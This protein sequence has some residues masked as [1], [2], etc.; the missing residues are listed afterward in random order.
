MILKID[1]PKIRDSRILIITI[2]VNHISLLA[3]PYDLTLL[4]EL[5][6]LFEPLLFN[7]GTHDKLLTKFLLYLIFYFKLLIQNI[8]Q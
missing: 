5:Y 2:L 8:P 3:H 7:L 1:L 6:P 4:T